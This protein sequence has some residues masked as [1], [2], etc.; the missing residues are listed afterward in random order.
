MVTTDTEDGSYEKG[1]E[2]TKPEF[3][4]MQKRAGAFVGAGAE[5]HEAGY[6]AW[7]LL[8]RDRPDS[9]DDRRVCFECKHLRENARCRPGYLPLRFVLQRCEGFELKGAGRAGKTRTEESKG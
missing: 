8:R 4:R 7:R 1:S 6:L 2:W 5:P 9:G 3:E